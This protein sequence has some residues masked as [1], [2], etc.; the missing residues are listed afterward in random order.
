[1]RILL[2]PDSFK[3]SLTSVQAAAAMADGIRSVRA[4][5]KI[6]TMP[7]ADGGEGTRDVLHTIYG[8]EVHDEILYFEH[9]GRSCALIESALF[10]GVMLPAM[11]GHVFERG[12]RPLGDALSAV[13]DAGVRD[14]HIALGGSATVDGGLGLLMALGWQVLDAEGN[15]V[16][17]DLYG[18]MQA[19]EII[20]D[21]LDQ[22]LKGVSI[23]LLLD[24][25]NPLCGKNGAVE[26]YGA[27]KGIRDDQAGA[28]EAAMRQWADLCELR[29]ALSVQELSGAGA[30]GGL[31]FALLLLS[32][33]ADMQA[34]S[35]ADYV[36]QASHFENALKSV[37]WVV[38]GEGQSDG[39][40]LQGKL[41]LMVARK[42]RQTSVSV[43]LISGEICDY[44]MLEN[45]FDNIIVVR[46]DNRSVNESMRYAERYLAQAAARWMQEVDDQ[47]V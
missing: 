28:V 2:A 5:V 6:I 26:V 39:Q 31:G 38:T 21:T 45:H 33:V 9:K 29:T 41:P 15:P 19:R 46:P 4:D 42:A 18:L 43:A 22:R 40:T 3:G 35:G 25:Q 10:V 7:M 23:T 14:I 27:Q 8:G 36:M 44:K 17:A 1:M 32:G 47:C 11:Q 16:S 13:L 24:V 37:H 20:I 30:A 34:V 12:S